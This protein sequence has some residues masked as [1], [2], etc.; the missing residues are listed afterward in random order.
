MYGSRHEFYPIWEI[1][2][3]SLKVLQEQIRAEALRILLNYKYISK[4]YQTLSRDIV[5]RDLITCILSLS[6]M[7][8]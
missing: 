4:E 2:T 8:Y 3:E 6:Q 5:P 1:K 7:R